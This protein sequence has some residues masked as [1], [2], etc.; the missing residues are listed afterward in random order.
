[1]GAG[2][3]SP[4]QRV[5]TNQTTPLHTQSRGQSTPPK[6]SGSQAP[7]S[8]PNSPEVHATKGVKPKSPGL[9][10]NAKERMERTYRGT[11]T[12]AIPSLSKVP[13]WSQIVGSSS[14]SSNTQEAAAAQSVGLSS[15]PAAVS[16]VPEQSLSALAVQPVTYRW[17]TAKAGFALPDGD[18]D[19]RQDPTTRRLQV[20]RKLGPLQIDEY[21]EDG[22]TALGYF[23]KHL[24]WQR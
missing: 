18:F 15:A 12:A 5:P 11:W 3:A 2:S 6:S 20:R 21:V 19:Y 1:M 14:Q 13:G 10:A 4:E 16:S 22:G 9:L 24:F 7:E 17:T 23:C 8:T